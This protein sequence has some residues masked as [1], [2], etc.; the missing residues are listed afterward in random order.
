MLEL[1]A[2]RRGLEVLLPDIVDTHVLIET[3]N[4]TAAAYVNKMGGGF[5]SNADSVQ[6]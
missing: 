4:V 3:A 5:Q 6:C 1:E 2:I